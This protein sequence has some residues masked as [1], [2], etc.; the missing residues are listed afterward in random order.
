MND[1]KAACACSINSLYCCLSPTVLPV[2]GT[3]LYQYLVE[4]VRSCLSSASR[5]SWPGLASNAGMQHICACLCGVCHFPAQA[6]LVLAAGCRHGLGGREAACHQWLLHCWLPCRPWGCRTHQ[7]H[8]F[9][10]PY[11]SSSKPAQLP[12]PPP[13]P[14]TLLSL[15]TRPS[16]HTTPQTCSVHTG[17]HVG[18]RHNDSTS[19]LCT[20]L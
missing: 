18:P 9:L 17:M 8:H 4:C 7:G 14:L 12:H 11:P 2:L 16:Q 13:H 3:Q 5:L 6:L 19:N 20:D 10:S 15:H 1:S